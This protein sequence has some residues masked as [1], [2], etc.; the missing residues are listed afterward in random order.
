MKKLFVIALTMLLS[1]GG[2]CQTDESAAETKD[3]TEC[4]KKTE[5]KW[6]G[7]C[8]GCTESRKT[9]KVK[10]V[11]ACGENLS[12]KLAVQENHKRWKTYSRQILLPNDTISGFAC[13]GTGKYL[14]WAKRADDNT[15]DLPTDEE[16]NTQ[17]AK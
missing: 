17:F 14:Y 11:N 4:L 8:K 6:G 16:I 15:V 12:V 10:F 13:V 1:S 9:Y 7:V 3:Y 2:F 5:F